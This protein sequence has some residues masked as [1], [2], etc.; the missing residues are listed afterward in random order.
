MPVRPS[1]IKMKCRECGWECVF[2]P[3]NDV[4]LKLPQC[5]GCGADALVYTSA[6]QLDRLKVP[7]HALRRFM[8]RR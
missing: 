5:P 8:G 3:P 7:L 1:A 4:L 6:G 2:R